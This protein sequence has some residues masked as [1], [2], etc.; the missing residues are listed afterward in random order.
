M[1]TDGAGE[2]ARTTAG[3]ETGATGIRRGLGC[4]MKK[5]CRSLGSALPHRIIAMGPRTRFARDDRQF[6]LV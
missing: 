2:D 6:E 5:K 1:T 3:Q 4:W